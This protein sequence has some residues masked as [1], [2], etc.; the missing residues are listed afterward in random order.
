V[1]PG[2]R[3]VSCGIIA[4]R[5]WILLTGNMAQEVGDTPV[6][7]LTMASSL[8][9]YFRDALASA[10][11]NQGVSPQQQATEHYLVALLEGYA[12]GKLDDEA[13]AL[14]LKSALEA[15]PAARAA[16]LRELA[17]RAL[18]VSGFFP[19]SIPG[20]KGLIDVDYFMSMGESAYGLLA[21]GAVRGTREAV[22][23]PVFGELAGR[24]GSFVEVLNEVS[25]ESRLRSDRDLVKL[26]ERFL[27]TGSGWVKRQLEML[28]M[29]LGHRAA[30]H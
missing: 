7:T 9:D 17:D 3:V 20:R 18:F 10:L 26:Y 11:R 29:S 16:L 8:A 2:V 25:S 12:L 23:Q 5:L 21:Q 15:P 1:A 19:G 28:G 6:C 24:F 27:R 4:L 13:L 22:H 30:V 14:R